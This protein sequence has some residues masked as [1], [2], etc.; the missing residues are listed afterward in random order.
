MLT[1]LLQTCFFEWC[2]CFFRYLTTSTTV[3]QSTIKIMAEAL[4]FENEKGIILFSEIKLKQF[5][6]N[7]CS[8]V[9]KPS[10]A[11]RFSHKIL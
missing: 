9:L 3:R 7:A 4:I 2:K 8:I 1:E 10:A 6:T 11:G 5:Y